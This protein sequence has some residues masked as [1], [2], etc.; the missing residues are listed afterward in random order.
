MKFFG[1]KAE[2]EGREAPKTAPK[3]TVGS[4]RS[5]QIDTQRAST[6]EYIARPSGGGGQSSQ[7]SG[8]GG[9]SGY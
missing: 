1:S 6:E 9:G 4:E 3:K 2:L 7:S 8:G 5:I